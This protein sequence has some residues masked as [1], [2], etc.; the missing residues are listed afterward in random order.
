MQNYNNFIEQ[1]RAEVN[2]LQQEYQRNMQNLNE[3][4]RVYQSQMQN[5]NGWGQM[6]NQMQQPPVQQQP[7]Q[8][9][10]GIPVPVQQLAATGEI[11]SLLEKIG[12]TLE[13]I[14]D[15]LQK[16]PVKQNES[17]P[18]RTEPEKKNESAKG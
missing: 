18:P 8:A 1:H 15:S 2:R 9:E 16:E 12:S 10:Q 11:K 17:K 4:L 13:G 7:V 6:P 5:P 14:R 3:S